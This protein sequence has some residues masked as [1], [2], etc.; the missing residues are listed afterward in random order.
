MK[1]LENFTETLPEN[2]ENKKLLGNNENTALEGKPLL[3]QLKGT[4]KV[5]NVKQKLKEKKR[6][7][8]WKKKKMEKLHQMEVEEKEK[9]HQVETEKEKKSSR[10]MIQKS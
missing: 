4:I 5:I 6:D 8:K 10:I 9:Q 7:V 3:N 1:E 2:E